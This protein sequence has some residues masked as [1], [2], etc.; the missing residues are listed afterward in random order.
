MVDKPTLIIVKVYNGEWEKKK[1]LE[2]YFSTRSVTKYSILKFIKHLNILLWKI[3]QIP[4]SDI[5][6][7]KCTPHLFLYF[8]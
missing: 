5:L 4:L 6:Y 8:H 3:R 7:L 1:D 2:K